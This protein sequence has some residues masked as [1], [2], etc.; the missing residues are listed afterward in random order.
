M[1]KRILK[2]IDHLSLAKV[3]AIFYGA[4]GLIGGLIYIF[5]FLI[6]AIIGGIISGDSSVWASISVGIIFAAF[7]PLMISGMYAGI[8]FV[9]GLLTALVWNKIVVRLTGGLIFNVEPYT[10]PAPKV[11]TPKVSAQDTT[12]KQE[13]S[14]TKKSTPKAKK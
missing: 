3:M 5:F 7:V 4:M 1:N 6:V 10:E 2:E 9:F 8:G 12:K 13:N 14:S 11:S